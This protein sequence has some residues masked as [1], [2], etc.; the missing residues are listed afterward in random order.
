MCTWTAW[1]GR[2]SAAPVHCSPYLQRMKPKTNFALQNQIENKLEKIISCTRKYLIALECSAPEHKYSSK[3][4]NTQ[5]EQKHQVLDKPFHTSIILQNG[6]PK[7]LCLI[8]SPSPSSGSL[9]S[10]Q[11]TRQKK[12]QAET[13]AALASSLSGN[14]GQIRASK[15]GTAPPARARTAPCPQELHGNVHSPTA[16]AFASRGR[17]NT[18]SPSG[19]HSPSSPGT[20]LAW[21]QSRNPRLPCNCQG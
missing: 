1:C 7:S 19:A 4:E 17:Q 14:P 10:L 20:Q 5:Y 15:G 13:V 16:A 3:K 8:P 18:A 2:V 12:E 9:H 11:G 21:P 6:F